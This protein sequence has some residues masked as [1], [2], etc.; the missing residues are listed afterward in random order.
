[1]RDVSDAENEELEAGQ[2][3]DK[4]H[5]TEKLFP[6]DEGDRGV[7]M[8]AVM[9]VGERPGP[10][11]DLMGEPFVSREGKLVRQLL[12][13]AGIDAAD[14]N[15]TYLVQG[16]PGT[17]LEVELAAVRPRVLVSLGEGPHGREL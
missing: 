6:G 7:P 2:Q 14:C 16:G 4:W 8:A 3:V 17:L 13:Q 9:V 12:A 15:F 10:E 5:E 1:M 11:E